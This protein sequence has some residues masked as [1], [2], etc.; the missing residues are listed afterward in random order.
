MKKIVFYISVLIC[1]E[2]TGLNA[3]SLKDVDGN[4]YASATIG[5]QIWMAE[6]LKTTKFNDGT[7]IPF[8]TKNSVWTALKTPGYSWFENNGQN[9]EIYGALYNWFAVDTKKLCPTGWHVPTASEWKILVA[10]VGDPVRAADKIKEAGSDHWK[11]SLTIATNEYDF[12]ALPGGFRLYTGGF[13][14]PDCYAV[15]WSSTGYDETQAWNWGL[16]FSSSRIYNGFDQKRAGF[17]IR[18]LKDN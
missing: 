11:T 4:V 12:S 1:F 5:K 9:K 6:N 18:C 10:F 7:P 3:Q 15:W 13:P 14:D 8:I 2:F 17:S 16:F